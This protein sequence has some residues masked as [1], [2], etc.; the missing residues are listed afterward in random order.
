MAACVPAADRERAVK[1]V[2]QAYERIKVQQPLLHHHHHH[3][4]GDQLLAH[5]L[6]GEAMRALD[7][8]LSVML[9][10]QQQPA[11]VAQQPPSPGRDDHYKPTARR[12]SKRQ[13]SSSSSSVV[14]EEAAGKNKNP[15]SSS[16]VNLTTMPYDDGYVW[17]KYGEKTINGTSYTRSYF[18]CTYKYD[19]GCQ[20]TKHVQQQQQAAGGNHTADPPMFQ[21]T[22][23]NRHT[24]NNSISSQAAAMP[25]LIQVS[26]D[27]VDQ[28]T[29][30]LSSSQ[31]PSLSPMGKQQFC[32]GTAA[33]DISPPPPN[34][35]GA[36]MID[37]E[38]P[39]GGLLPPVLE[40]FSALL[41]LDQTPLM[42]QQEPLFPII[43]MQ[44]FR[45]N[46]V[47]LGE[48]CH[49]GGDDAAPLSATT[50]CMAAAEASPAD[51]PLYDLEQ[52][53]L[54]DSDY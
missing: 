47:L 10:Q 5:S 2:A 21:V 27:D 16:W 39:V 45:D 33:M 51:D 4:S 30:L 41:P 3:C 53:L 18:R 13:R 52:F 9:Q 35:H 38:T 54:S 42:C 31:E 29:P 32:I 11:A 12:G 14:M 22:Y 48:D 15:S 7:I 26:D 24:C 28:T 43:S 34:G 37:T 6:L 40:D 20:A 19:T 23:N 1:E 44:R 50:T 25:S 46:T 8:A 17:R 36:A 49:G